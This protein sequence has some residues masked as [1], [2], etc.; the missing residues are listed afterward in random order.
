MRVPPLGQIASAVWNAVAVASRTVEVNTK[1][2]FSLTAGSY[3]VRASSTQRGSATMGGTVGTADITISS[4]TEAR[5]V[6]VFA[7]FYTDNTVAL[8]SSFTACSLSAATTVTLIRSG[9]SNT[10][11]GKAE[12]FELF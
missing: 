1:T 5:A 8:N 10:V 12:V 2:G 9:T 7:G 11:I 3:S 4:V 6:A